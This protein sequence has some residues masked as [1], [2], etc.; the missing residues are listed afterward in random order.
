MEN[1][2]IQALEAKEGKKQHLQPGRVYSVTVE[3]SKVLIKGG[4]AKKANPSMSLG[5]VY[6]LPKDKNGAGDDFKE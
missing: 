1:V 3:L 5:K 6:D 2:N 4:K